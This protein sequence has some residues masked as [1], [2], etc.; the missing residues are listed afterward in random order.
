[1]TLLAPR[2]ETPPP[3]PQALIPEAR[4]RGRRRRA[5]R[6][7]LAAVAALVVAGTGLSLAAAWNA[8]TARAH[9]GRLVVAASSP[10]VATCDGG[11]V[12]A[13]TELTLS[14]ADANSALTGTRWTSWGTASARGVTT[15]ALNPCTPY[16]A[17]S[18]IRHFAGATVVLDRPVTTA[19]GTRFSR[20]VVTYRAG[21]AVR[22]YVQLLTTGGR[23]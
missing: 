21:G 6:A 11:A 15:L 10:R 7:G 2:P 19:S 9:P 22:T 17:A 13:P 3:P 1:M 18:P 8:S 14:C 16:C 4:R 20:A 5:R 12:V 23:A